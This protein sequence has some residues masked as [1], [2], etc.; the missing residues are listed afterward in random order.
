MLNSEDAG[1]SVGAVLVGRELL[2]VRLP[3][4]SF[5]LLPLLLLPLAWVASWR[6]ELVEGLERVDGREEPITL[7]SP[8][9]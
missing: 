6:R 3:Q 8:V 1:L 9:E 7:A 4:R 5:R 2:T